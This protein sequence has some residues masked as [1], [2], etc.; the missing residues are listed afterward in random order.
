ML[1][2]SQRILRTSCY[3]VVR[4]VS[5]GGLL[6]QEVLLRSVQVSINMNND[7]GA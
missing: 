1:I 2:R 4:I 5:H 6:Y 3:R 7:M